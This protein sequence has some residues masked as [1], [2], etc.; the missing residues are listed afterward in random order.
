MPAIDSPGLCNQVASRGEPLNDETPSRK[1][2]PLRRRNFG[3]QKGRV[4]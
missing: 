2:K 3:A 1:G 4:W